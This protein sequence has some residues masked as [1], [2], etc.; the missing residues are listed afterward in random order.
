MYS[1]YQ[2]YCI[3][4]QI[5]RRIYVIDFKVLQANYKK[6]EFKMKNHYDQESYFYT[7]PIGKLKQLGGLIK[8]IE[9]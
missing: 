9:Y 4:S 8:V 7:L 3:V 6:G 5:E 2:I 1:D